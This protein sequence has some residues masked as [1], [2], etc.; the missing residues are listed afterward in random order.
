VL[1]LGTPHGNFMPLKG[2]LPLQL[3]P[4]TGVRGGDAAISRRSEIAVPGMVARAI[5]E[6]ATALY[7]RR[8]SYAR[9]ARHL[10][11]EQ[12]GAIPVMKNSAQ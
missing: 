6:A 5:D 12:G 3:L 8:R 10:D 7:E 2:G 11:A 1:F 4:G 9:R